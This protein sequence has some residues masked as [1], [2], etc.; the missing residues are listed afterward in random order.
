M[1]SDLDRF[2]AELQT[3][4]QAAKHQSERVSQQSQALEMVEAGSP[5]LE[6][7]TRRCHGCNGWVFWVSIHDAVIGTACHPP[8]DPGLVRRWYWLP[9]G[10]CTRTQ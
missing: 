4:P 8:A 9:E 10:E 2:L 3:E 6:L 5:V 1:V 7:P